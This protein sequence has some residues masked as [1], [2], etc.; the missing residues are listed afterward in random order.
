LSETVLVGTPPLSIPSC[1]LK[2]WNPIRCTCLNPE[3]KSVQRIHYLN[4]N[5]SWLRYTSFVS[6]EKWCCSDT[7][8]GILFD[9][10]FCDPEKKEH[11]INIKEEKK[12]QGRQING[13]ERN[14]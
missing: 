1:K 5:I 4:N 12:L 7:H 6:M 9:F 8:S 10:S 3:P 2:Y 14:W 13:W 11:H